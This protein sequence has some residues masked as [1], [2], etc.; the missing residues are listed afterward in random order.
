MGSQLDPPFRSFW[1]QL[2]SYLNIAQSLRDV[3]DL[4]KW[5]AALRNDV[6]KSLS[7][8]PGM[9]SIPRVPSIRLS[10]PVFK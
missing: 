3:D 9:P 2:P 7:V 5:I 10:Y 1:A 6:I 8:F 4:V